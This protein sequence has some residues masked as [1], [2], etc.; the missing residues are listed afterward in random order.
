MIRAVGP[1][2][3]AFGVSGALADPVLKIFNSAG[4]Q[5]NLNDN[6]SGSEI[7]TANATT[8]AFPLVV[9]SK[10]AALLLNLAA[11]GYTAQVTDTSGRA[12][13]VLTEVYDANGPTT[14]PRFVN[15]STRAPVAP[16]S[17]L[18][19]GFVITAADGTTTQKV[20]I[21]GVGPGIAK[22]GVSS[23]LADP[24]LK[25]YDSAGAVIAQSND[26]SG[27]D[28]AAAAAATGA[29]ALDAGSKDA[30]LLLTLA[31]GG[32]TFEITAAPNTAAG[33]AL[34]DIYAAP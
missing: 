10:D 2:L 5:V 1:G 29:F 6:W 8:G 28:I 26:W 17:P 30:A 14:T 19:G 21:R 16:G 31:P 27:S 11:G 18:V 23:P 34:A 13:V 15:L 32:Y 20:L 33:E 4:A 12:G 22:F 7:T 25:V 9:G 3:T 24:V